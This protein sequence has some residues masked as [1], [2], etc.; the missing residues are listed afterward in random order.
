[1]SLIARNARALARVA[2]K[3]TRSY[4]LTVEAPAKEWAA[5]R[6]AVKDHA[7]GMCCSFMCVHTFSRIM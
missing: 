5:K 4:A 3:N 7:A 2:P 1:M 6:Q